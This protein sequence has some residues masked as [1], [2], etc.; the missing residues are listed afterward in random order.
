M[1]YVEN[2]RQ[3]L[4]S[5]N[6]IKAEYWAIVLHFILLSV[7]LQHVQIRSKVLKHAIEYEN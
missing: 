3:S 6:M 5:D 2:M 7:S 4:F 1:V